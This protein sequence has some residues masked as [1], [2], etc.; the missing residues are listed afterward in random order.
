MLSGWSQALLSG[1]RTSGK[2]H[3]LK[4]KNCLNKKKLFL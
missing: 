3:K 4:Y 1:E 2:G